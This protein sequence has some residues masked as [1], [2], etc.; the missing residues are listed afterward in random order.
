MRLVEAGNHC[1]GCVFEDGSDLNS[2]Q[3]LR[4]IDEISLKLP[5]FFI[6]R[7]DIRYETDAGLQAGTGFKI[8]ELN[9]AA[10]EATN[11]YDEHNSLWR[12]YVTLYRQWQLVY[13]IGAANRKLGASPVSAHA[14]WSD[15]RRFS[16]Q[17]CEYPVAD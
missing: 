11:I 3:L 8:I 16:Q 15:W 10:S 4:A 14:L 1:Q 12:A 9:G 13:A 5:G 2:D 7:F 17:A 6:G